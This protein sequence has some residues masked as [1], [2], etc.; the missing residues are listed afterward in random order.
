MVGYQVQKAKT[1]VW[2]EVDLCCLQGVFHPAIE[3]GLA[4]GSTYY[5]STTHNDECYVLCTSLNSWKFANYSIY[6]SQQILC[7]T[8]TDRRYRVSVFKTTEQS[9]LSGAAKSQIHERPTKTRTL[10]IFSRLK[11]S[12]QGFL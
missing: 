11:F 9:R 2:T 5:K 6:G 12:A 1:V 3:A 7:R 8:R 10:T 4:S